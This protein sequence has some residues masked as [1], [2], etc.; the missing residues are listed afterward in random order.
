MET[1]SR[2]VEQCDGE[3]IK[4]VVFTLVDLV[5]RAVGTLTKVFNLLYG[6]QNFCSL[7]LMLMFSGEI[8]FLFKIVD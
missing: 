4:D 2:C 5:K 3:V 8:I 6:F 7:I 1:A